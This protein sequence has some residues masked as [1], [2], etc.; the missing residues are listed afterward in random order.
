MKFINLGMICTG[1]VT[2]KKS[3]DEFFVRHILFINPTFAE[4]LKAE[5][6]K[7]R[8]RT[9][10]DWLSWDNEEGT[11]KYAD[12]EIQKAQQEYWQGKSLDT[13]SQAKN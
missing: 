2:E 1:D 9:I 12:P 3:G 6:E 13:G 11:V 7:V 10:V 8:I 5:E 4:W